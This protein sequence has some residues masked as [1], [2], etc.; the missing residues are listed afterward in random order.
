MLAVAA[1]YRNL[2]LFYNGVEIRRVYQQNGGGVWINCG[3]QKMGVCASETG[4][5]VHRGH[6]KTVIQKQVRRQ[7]QV[8]PIY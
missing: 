2:L 4:V 1:A 5:S 6:I 3:A 7:N 8:L